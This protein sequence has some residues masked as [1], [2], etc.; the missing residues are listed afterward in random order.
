[1]NTEYALARRQELR[2]IIKSYESFLN[3]QTVRSENRVKAV[4]A[5]TARDLIRTIAMSETSK[6]RINRITTGTVPIIGAA[7]VAPTDNNP[8]P[9]SPDN[10][11]GQ[12]HE[13]LFKNIKDCLPCNFK[14]D[15]KDFDWDRLKE[16]LEM[17]LKSRLKFL[18][19]I[20]G[21]F[22]GNPI[23][24]ELCKFLHMLRDLCPKDILVLIAIMTSYITRVLEQIDF[25]LESALS[26]I[27]SGLL[28]PYIG[29]L[30]DFLTIY[31]QF[32]MDQIDCILNSIENAAMSIK[33]TKAQIASTVNTIDARF[34]RDTS[35]KR[36]KAKAISAKAK[37]DR[38]TAEAKVARDKANSVRTAS[39]ESRALAAE[40]AAER[41]SEEALL[42]AQGT[43][44]AAQESQ[45]I[46]SSAKGESKKIPDTAAIE[47]AS[48]PD[49]SGA[50]SMSA[51]EVLDDIASKAQRTKKFIHGAAD[52]ASDMDPAEDLFAFI[53]T[54]TRE[55]MEWTESNLTKA[56]DAIIDLLGGEWLITDKNISWVQ[57]IKA[58]ATIIDILE[59]IVSLGDIDELCSEDNVKKIINGINKRSPAGD[60][61]TIPASELPN[62]Q[63]DILQPQLQ[64]TGS[65]TP[66]AP[67]SSG[68]TVSFKLKTCLRGSSESD[69]DLLRKWM[70]ELE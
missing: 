2:L 20:E 68:R 35:Q 66:P 22:N 60:I 46:T 16:I 59:V 53:K 15:W 52:E 37:A 54:I 40:E 31:L 3:R 44:S 58:V 7:P 38:L 9:F 42:A 50:K 18:D 14:W 26:D 47:S 43:A 64:Q 49:P 51:D 28:R 34:S 4:E 5:L 1:M 55:V 36:A 33:Q 67:P 25:N 13:Q 32:L 70:V 10:P 39:A 48:I 17:D 27:L 61:V 69:I 45:N 63:G 6:A 56:Q 62:P 30:E 19:D 23:L 41:A 8:V 11:S 65:Q 24:D 57:T 12:N 21:L 29:G